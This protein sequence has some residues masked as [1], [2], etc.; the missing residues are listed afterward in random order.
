M[1]A[2]LTSTTPETP[3]EA[4]RLCGGQRLVG[5][6]ERESVQASAESGRKMSA[7]TV[8][9]ASAWSAGIAWL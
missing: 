7:A 9:A 1:T 2:S 6:L 4:R 8:S 3:A 5:L